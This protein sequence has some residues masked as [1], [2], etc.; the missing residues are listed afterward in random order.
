M[1]KSPLGYWSKQDSGQGGGGGSLPD[2]LREV[3]IEPT[4]MVVM[5]S[6]RFLKYV[7]SPFFF[8]M[9]NPPLP[10]NVSDISFLWEFLEG[11]HA[12]LLK[13]TQQGSRSTRVGTYDLGSETRRRGWF[14]CKVTYKGVEYVSPTVY[15]VF[16]H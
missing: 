1:R 16:R 13:F 4:D 12:N 11:G 9:T 15:I 3:W 7:V 8:V 2:T 10:E 14:Q 5:C 6:G